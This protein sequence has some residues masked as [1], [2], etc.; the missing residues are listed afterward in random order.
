MEFSNEVL[1][2]LAAEVQKLDR[3]KRR[4]NILLPL[5]VGLVIL[6]SLSPLLFQWIEAKRIGVS[7]WVLEQAREQKRLWEINL[8]CLNDKNAP[9]STRIEKNGIS[10]EVT[11][12]P[13]GDTL[14]AFGKPGQAPIMYR[15]V[16]APRPE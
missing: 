15:W 2:S 10:V 7:V 12:C 11:V 4:R 9:T 5:I 8:N 6:G 3:K 16:K 1:Q 13:T 14:V